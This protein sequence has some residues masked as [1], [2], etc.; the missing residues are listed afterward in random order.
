MCCGFS[1]WHWFPL[2]L[3]TFDSCIEFNVTS[4]ILRHVHL[5]WGGQAAEIVVF[6]LEH[7]ACAMYC[8]SLASS[9]A[10]AANK[11]WLFVYASNGQTA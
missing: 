3:H 11:D 5:P 8:M 1:A 4:L 9:E 6:V 10:A 2:K 7:A